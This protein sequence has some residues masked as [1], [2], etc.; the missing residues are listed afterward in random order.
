MKR[1]KIII[2]SI[3]I[4]L[5]GSFIIYSSLPDD[6]DVNFAGSG[7][8]IMCHVSDGASNTYNGEDVSPVSLWRSTMMAHAAKDPLWRA[9]VSEETDVFP[10]MKELIETTCTRCHAPMGNTKSM[11]EGNE[12]FT[13]NDL[14]KSAL[15]LDGVSCTLCHQVADSLLG[16]PETYS[17]HYQIGKDRIIYGPY[18]NPLVEVMANMVNFTPRYSKHVNQSELCATC[19]TLFTPFFDMDNKF[20]GYFPEQTP[21][22]EWKNSVYGIAQVSCQS[23]HMPQ[24][25]SPVDIST[26]PP[27]HNEGRFPFWKH[28]F[29]GGNH[30]MLNLFK[31]NINDL[32]LDASEQQ[33]SA[34]ISKLKNFVSAAIEIDVK[35]EYKDN[36]LFVETQIFNNSGHKFPTGIPFRRA[37]IHLKVFN[38]NKEVVFESGAFNN[39]G[40]IINYDENYEPH[41]LEID[42]ENK[43]QVYEG[44]F[45]N[46][47]GEVTQTLL[48]ASSYIKD[49]RIPPKGFSKTHISYDSIAIF[50]NANEDPDFGSDGSDRTIYKIQTSDNGP[51]EIIAELY[52]QTVKYE[53]IEHLKL[54]GTSDINKFMAMYDAG[55]KTPLLIS[56]SSTTVIID[57]IEDTNSKTGY[58]YPNPVTDIVN[59]PLKYNGAINYTIYDNMGRQ[60]KKGKKLSNNDLIKIN[61]S[62][63]IKG[64]YFVNINSNQYTERIKILKN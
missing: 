30:L 22:L 49:N 62:E 12:Y 26:R 13:F 43:V 3:S 7:T 31:N 23:C 45:V 17:G 15:G 32:G 33:Y 11:F 44:V 29:V 19:H 2:S 53:T 58:T 41:Y 20:G 63:F 21:Y 56:A 10:E 35:A 57:G 14:D 46:T 51:Y 50:G 25:N 16:N 61:I 36:L 42:D 47:S 24:I 60:V 40:K 54:I 39:N 5:F 48:R 64:S 59:I 28:D 55:D 4:L 34:T 1:I 18:E 37:W 8:C 38:V 6:N 52:Y 27:W 9:V